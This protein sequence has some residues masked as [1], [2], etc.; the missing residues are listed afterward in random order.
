MAEYMSR[1]CQ[2]GQIKLDPR[3][4]VD[5][6]GGG[7]NNGPLL[8]TVQKWSN[9]NFNLSPIGSRHIEKQFFAQK[10]GKMNLKKIFCTFFMNST[11]KTN[12]AEKF[13]FF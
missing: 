8:Q 2:N 11:N 1:L 9:N 7:W 6:T 13:Q 5:T 12:P 10:E 4:A 3:G